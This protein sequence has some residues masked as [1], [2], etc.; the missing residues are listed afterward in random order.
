MAASPI[1]YAALAKQAGAVQSQPAKPDY[2]KLAQQAGA[3]KSELRTN[4]TPPAP[5]PPGILTRFGQVLGLPTSMEELKAMQPPPQTLGQTV[6]DTA[7]GPVGTGIKVVKGIGQGIKNAYQANEPEFEEAV[8]NIQ[9]GGPVGANLGKAGYS[10]VKGTLEG[11][12]A[13][14]GG[15]VVQNAGEDAGAK[16]DP[17]HGEFSMDNPSGFAGD[18]LGVTALTALS[19]MGGKPTQKT[20]VNKLSSAIGASGGKVN[21]P[22]ALR[23]ALPELNSAAASLGKPVETLGDLQQVVKEGFRQTENEYNTALHPIAAQPVMATPIADLIRAEATK[24]SPKNTAEARMRNM[25]LNRAVEYDQ[26][27]TYGELNQQRMNANG[28]LRAFEGQAQSAQQASLRTK[29]DV[30]VDK[31]IADGSRDLVYDK[32]QSHYGKD[33]AALKGRQ[34]AMTTIADRLND[35]VNALSNASS[36]QAGTP[37]L[38]R[39]GGSGYMHPGSAPGVSFHRLQNLL[40]FIDPEGAANSATKAAFSQGSVVPRAA[41]GAIVG[42]TALFTP[43]Y[44]SPADVMEAM[45]NGELDQVSGNAMLQKMKGRNGVITRPLAPPQ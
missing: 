44:N 8:K 34:A 21:Y 15:N 25:L 26:P 9:E 43:Q 29:V 37:P 17:I 20:Q 22:E 45:K 12:L 1:D 5:P 28:R 7:L 23:T 10:V 4:I 11:P 27:W 14:V 19:M 18:A 16:F 41:A 38:T 3:M 42:R 32:L 13:P 33:F 31:A 24:L 39:L 30:M 2:A 35:Q 36:V 6:A 40:P